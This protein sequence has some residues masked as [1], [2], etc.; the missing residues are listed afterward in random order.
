MGSTPPD[1]DYLAWKDH[2]ADLFENPFPETEP[3]RLQIP[4]DQ[5]SD[6]LSADRDLNSSH[7]EN[8]TNLDELQVRASSDKSTNACSSSDS[9]SSFESEGLQPNSL[10]IGRSEER[11]VGKEC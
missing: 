4:P 8:Q 9:E 2:V 11:R 5:S 1:Y 7:G 6:Y 3:V 10:E